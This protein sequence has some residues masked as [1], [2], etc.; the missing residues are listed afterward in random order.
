MKRNSCP[1]SLAGKKG[2]KSLFTVFL[3][4]H[5]DSNEKSIFLNSQPATAFLP[6]RR[7][8]SDLSQKFRAKVSNVHYLQMKCPNSVFPAIPSAGEPFWSVVTCWDSELEQ[9]D[10][11]LGWKGDG[12]ALWVIGCARV[13]SALPGKNVTVS[14]KLKGVS[15][16]LFPWVTSH[17][18]KIHLLPIQLSFVWQN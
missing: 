12:A 17:K 11:V 7:P 9:V 1:Y 3:L 5:T 16:L 15:V 18:F 2:E 8:L 6:L 13:V 4:F 10:K 14:A